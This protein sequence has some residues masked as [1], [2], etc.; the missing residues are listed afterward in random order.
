MR[1]RSHITCF[2]GAVAVLGL[3]AGAQAAI[4]FDNFGPGDA[5]ADFGRILEGEGVG[6]IGN[7]DQASSFT[8]G[9][10]SYFL[11]SVSLGIFVRSSPSIGTGPLDIVLAADAGG[12]PGATLRTFPLNVNVTGKQIVTGV[13]DGS[14][15][16]NANTTYWVIADGKGDFDG[17]WYF[18]T[19][20]DVG[21]TAGRTNNGAWNLRPDDDRYALR[22]EG[23]VVPEPA[24]LALLGL[25]ILGSI[26]FARNRRRSIQA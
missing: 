26:G 2:V 22:V 1:S 10:D 24:S 4:I 3:A 17:A 11:T 8:V 23:R 15:T 18:N 25:G 5:F 9:P 19:T 7:V 13:D 6:S 20:G 12:S 16:L 14:F 21:L